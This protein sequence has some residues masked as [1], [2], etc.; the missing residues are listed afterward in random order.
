MAIVICPD[1]GKEQ[2]NLN[3]FCRNCGAD[4]SKVEVV[5]ETITDSSQ[6][7]IDGFG[8]D[9]QDSIAGNVSGSQDYVVGISDSSQGV[10]SVVGISDSSQGADSVSMVE[11]SED[12]GFAKDDVKAEGIKKCSVCG[13]DLAPNVRFCPNCG[14]S[15]DDLDEKVSLSSCPSCGTEIS[16][17]IKFCP[18]C[19]MN[20]NQ[21]IAGSKN[22][23]STVVEKKTPVV[24]VLLSVLFP[25]LGQFYNGQ[26]TKGL[27]FLG[28]AIV[29][30]VLMII[31]IGI[32]CYALVWLWSIF[33]A[34]QSVN[35][36]ND[37]KVIEDKLF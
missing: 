36:I 27:C 9:S 32:L 30:W 18:N 31:V 6:V 7:P 5:E 2:D 4:L 35:A 21:N 15:V 29:S 22:L 16:P 12:L 10:Y 14:K 28:L 24:A 20:L 8:S 34:Y 26:S 23:T 33:D 37:G 25:G 1:C 3:K 19:G 17:N 13:T 11:K